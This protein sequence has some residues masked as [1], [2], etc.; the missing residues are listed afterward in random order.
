MAALNMA[1]AFAYLDKLRASGVTNM[2]GAAPYVRAALSLSVDDAKTAHLAWMETYDG[3]SS[4]KD[5]AAK[6]EGRL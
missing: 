4:P 3:V 1:K 2:W 6:A 5:R